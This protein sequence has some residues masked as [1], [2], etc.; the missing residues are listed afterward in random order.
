MSETDGAATLPRPPPRFL[1]RLFQKFGRP[2]QGEP[3]FFQRVYNFLDAR[4]FVIE[5]HDRDVAVLVDFLGLRLGN[6][7]EGPTDPLPGEGSRA[8]RQEE[9]NDPLLCHRR[10]GA[11]EDGE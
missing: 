2:P 6:V 11:D 9:L 4:H 8:V 3:R 1:L 7:L 10:R 5:L